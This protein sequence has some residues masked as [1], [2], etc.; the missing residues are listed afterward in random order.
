MSDLDHTK[1]CYEARLHGLKQFFIS[2]GHSADEAADLSI[3]HMRGET[4]TINEPPDE[5]KEESLSQA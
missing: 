5:A 2:R 3:R 4:V 1:A